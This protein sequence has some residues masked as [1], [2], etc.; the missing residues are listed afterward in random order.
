VE[1]KKFKNSS[2]AFSLQAIRNELFLEFDTEDMGFGSSKKFPQV[3]KL[4]LF[5]TVALLLK[6]EKMLQYFYQTL[7]TMALRGL[8]DHVEGGFFRYATD[9]LWEIPH[10]EKMLYTQADMIVL[11]SR[12]YEHTYKK[13][14]KEII[15]ET[16]A[17]TKKRF[18][19]KNLFYSASDADS[20][21]DEGY[22]FTFTPK[23]L[24]KA[25]KENKHAEE[26]LDA[27][28]FIVEG[29]FGKRVHLSFDTQSRPKGYYELR[30]RLL[31]IRQKRH[32]PFIDKKINTA[33]NAMF[34]DALYKASVVDSK[35]KIEADRYKEALSDKMFFK[36]TPSSMCRRG[37]SDTKGFIRRLQ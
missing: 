30:K 37:K 36:G 29:N 8:Y 15:E 4:Q 5:Y 26:L 28:A 12:A 33:W 31:K 22:Y 11:Y 9:T 2:T 27:L 24:K 10:F 17:M 1:D 21:N 18:L 13:L 14:Y 34:I 32:Y 16:I 20:H 7:D 25:S 23:E 6:D 35:Y 19:H 3:Y